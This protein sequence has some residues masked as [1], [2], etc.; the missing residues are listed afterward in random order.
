MPLAVPLPGSIHACKFPCI[1]CEYYALQAKHL[2]SHV[3]YFHKNEESA[4]P[5]CESTYCKKPIN[6]KLRKKP[7]SFECG[8]CPYVDAKKG[9]LKDHKQF[10]HNTETKM[11]EKVNANNLDQ[12]GYDEKM[13]DHF[14]KEDQSKVAFVETNTTFKCDL[15]DHKTST[16]VDLKE[17]MRLEHMRGLLI[18]EDGDPPIV[19]GL[20][21]EPIHPVLCAFCN[22]KANN[23]TF[24]QKHLILV[25]NKQEIRKLATPEKATKHSPELAVKSEPA[26][27]PVSLEVE[28]RA[29]VRAV[30]AGR[31]WLLCAC[32]S[33][34][35]NP[36][37]LAAHQ[38]VCPVLQG[39][40]GG[41]NS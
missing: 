29:R 17:H 21:G 32:G 10:A 37:P 41:G 15:C 6:C 39:L 3:G 38:A 26:L 7:I 23:N 18:S 16:L 25:H 5:V 35:R 34:Y 27:P 1:H 4:K 40:P 30:R 22:F 33:R 31:G 20:T 24:L 36:G 2:V 8:E 14:K 11:K 28:A 19:C 9:N 13:G 12:F